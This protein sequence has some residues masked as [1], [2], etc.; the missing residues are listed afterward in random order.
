[1]LNFS[2]VEGAFG[3]VWQYLDHVIQKY[4]KIAIRLENTPC[5]KHTS[6]H[7]L[8]SVGRKEYK[9]T[10]REDTLILEIEDLWRHLTVERQS[11]SLT[12]RKLLMNKYKLLTI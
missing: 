3:L 12:P 5:I 8:I 7:A 11:F 10:K 6:L 9:Q 4:I 2:L 1:M